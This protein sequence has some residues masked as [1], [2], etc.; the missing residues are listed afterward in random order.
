ML[1]GPSALKM[2]STSTAF[3]QLAPAILS[4]IAW[5]VK[6]DHP[7]GDY[8]VASL[9]LRTL[10]RNFTVAL[11]RI[12]FRHCHV[13]SD[14]GTSHIYWGSLMTITC[15]IRFMESP[16]I[17]SCIR[18]LVM[19]IR[20]AR[21]HVHSFQQCTAA[22]DAAGESLITLSLVQGPS[23]L[24]SQVLPLSTGAKLQRLRKLAITTV[25]LPW[26]PS[27]LQRA[28]GLQTLEIT[29]DPRWT[30][31]CIKSHPDLLRTVSNQVQHVKQVQVE[32]E[33]DPR[34]RALIQ[35]LS[36]VPH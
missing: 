16:R 25:F 5:Y 14:N 12:I 11:T 26:L 7:T 9:R 30:V 6:E 20:C 1:A 22:L 33:E 21:D 34:H 10:N 8:L 28:S 15:F 2:T 32:H 36:R 31:K 19:D 4:R 18:E 17:Q 24:P 3:H 13:V 27:F 35:A 23:C 29:G